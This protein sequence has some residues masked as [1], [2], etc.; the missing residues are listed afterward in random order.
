VRVYKTIDAF[1]NDKKDTEIMRLYCDSASILAD[2]DS[3]RP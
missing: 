3:I 2:R 1:S